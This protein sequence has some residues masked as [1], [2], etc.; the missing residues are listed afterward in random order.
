MKKLL[1][2]L[3]LLWPCFAEAQT[4]PAHSVPIGQGAG[5]KS[6][7][8]AGPCSANQ[9]LLWVSGVTADPTCGLPASNFTVGTTV[10]SGGVS[11]RV[12]FD[13]AG[14]L[15]EYP[16]TG[17]AGNSVLSI[18]PTITTPIIGVISGGSAAGSTVTLQ[19][20]SSGSPVGDTANIFG[21]V[22]N[23]RTNGGT[24]VTSTINFG[25]VG[26]VSTTLAISSPTSN[27]VSLIPAANATGTLTFPTGGGTFST[28]TGTETPTNKTFVCANQASCVVRL[29]A[30]VSGVLPYA[31]GGCNATTQGGCTNNIF[32]GVTRAGDI[33]YWN[34][35]SWITLAGNN[36]GT[37][38][39]QETSSGVPSWVTISGTGTVT[40]VAFNAGLTGTTITTAGTGQLDGNYTGW[41]LSNCTIA[42]SVGSNLLT[43]SLKDNAG[44]DPSASSPCNI[45]YRNA[46][47]STGSLTLVQQ[48]TA[49][50]ISTNA[51]GAS[52]GSVANTAF[53]FWVVVFN[54]TGTNVLALFNAWDGSSIQPLNE[55]VLASTTPISGSATSAG[56]FYSPNGTTVSSKAYRI[57]G[58]IEYNSTG[59]TTPG[60]YASG[61][62][63]I[64]VFGSGIRKPGEV[65]QI[66]TTSYSTVGSTSSGGF[67]NLASGQTK[68]ITP[69]SA[70]NPIRVYSAGNVTTNATSNVGF[71]QVRGAGTAV[72]LP[73]FQNIPGSTAVYN[74]SILTW[75]FPNSISSLTYQIQGSTG[76]GT[77]NY[78]TSTFGA[79][80]AV[81][82]L[83]EIQG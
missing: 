35:A 58:Y 14:V 18:G 28:I 15:G 20:T 9:T 56:V 64:Q 82:E 75:D 38:V 69:T 5:T 74:L 65:V 61:P 42:A 19:S 11:G 71:R 81:I 12:L 1:L 59:L 24:G 36:S 16:V 57:L 47:A 41:A 49:I 43:V 60:T 8:T 25:V 79:S 54:N 27:F 31:N 72:G 2:A 26:G 21:T 46:T 45:N 10:I 13:N 34:G 80:G 70:A 4:Y 7:A 30:D 23:L 76:A 48:T 40:S 44:S 17:T 50:S 66:Q 73:T 62:N 51:T 67:A 55:G 52:L 68:T 39:L 29:T 77:L 3:A 22:V 78:P 33:V 32:P 83:Q 63:F 53:R 6:F 37:Q